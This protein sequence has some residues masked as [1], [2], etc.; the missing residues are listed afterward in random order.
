MAGVVLSTVCLTFLLEYLRIAGQFRMFM[1]A[2]FLIITVIFVPEG[3]GQVVIRWM[4]AAWKKM[5]P[6]APVIFVDK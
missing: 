2:A 1:Y 4:K 5:K 6:R 3:L